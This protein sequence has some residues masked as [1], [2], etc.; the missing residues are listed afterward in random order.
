MVD[1]PSRPLSAP[2]KTPKLRDYQ[3]RVIAEVYAQIQAGMRRILL[4]APTGSGKTVIASQLVAQAA[5]RNQR[6]LFLVHREVLVEQTWEKFQSFGLS[7]GFIKS[8]WQEDRTA[9]LQIASVQ[10][11]HRRHWWKSFNPD[12]VLL[13]EAHIVAW[14]S[15]V[16][17]MMATDCPDATYLGL[18]ATPWRLS[19]REGLGDKFEALVCAPLPAQ[20]IQAGHLAPLRYYGFDDH[21]DLSQVRTVAGEFSEPDLAVACDQPQLIAH[22]VQQWQR[23]CA[24]RQTIAFA[25]NVEHSKHIRDAFVQAGIAAE[26]VDGSTPIPERTAIYQRLA[27]GQTLVLSSCLVLTEGFDVCAVN[28]VILCRPTKSKALFF[29]MTGRGMRI[30][31]ETGKTDCIVLDQAG[32]VK[33]FGFVEELKDVQ[34]TPGLDPT[35]QEAYTKNCPSD[36]GGC[37]ATLYAFQL[38][39]PHCGYQYPPA[40]RLERTDD[41]VQL[42]SKEQRKKFAF[43][44]K[45]AKEALRK[46]LVPDHAS[47]R[48]KESF[49]EWPPKEFR[50]NAVFEGDTA[51]EHQATYRAYLQ[52]VAQREGKNEVW[53]QIYLDL[54]FGP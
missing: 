31:P 21:L 45:A 5:S 10:T 33:R 26:H 36:Q 22:I 42:L 11:L 37:D 23:L 12:L 30:S 43:Y 49:G 46:G 54:E 9:L 39:C 20:L 41:F 29:Q 6:V 38:A 51:A 28:A 34:L 18:T 50:Y 24:G 8:G 3:R 16:E 7:A 17:R 2:V 14:V 32:N 25:V 48:F 15:V 52:K 40:P 1:S 13:D 19:R 27:T 4:V 35:S 44:R 53:I 47:V